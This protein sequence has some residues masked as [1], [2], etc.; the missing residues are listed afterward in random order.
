MKLR[1]TIGIPSAALS[2]VALA[3]L[4]GVFAVG[5]RPAVVTASAFA[6]GQSGQSVPTRAFAW[7]QFNLFLS[8]GNGDNDW[9]PWSTWKT[10]CQ[11]GLVL[12]GP[13]CPPQSSNP[14]PAAPDLGTLVMSG[15]EIPV[16]DKLF[17]QTLKAPFDAGLLAGSV[18]SASC[19]LARPSPCGA[20]L[21]NAKAAG[22][23]Q[24]YGLASL[25]AFIS[26]HPAPS[27][28]P[29]FP[30]G[31]VIVK[32]VWGFLGS[33]TGQLSVWN[34]SD[35][36]FH[37][38]PVDR[39]KSR[40]CTAQAY[41][42]PDGNSN[43]QKI[44][45]DCFKSVLVTASTTPNPGSVGAGIHAVAGDHYV[46]LGIHI[47]RK[48]EAGWVWSTFWWSNDP[49][50]NPEWNGGRTGL[51][52][53]A[54]W[55]HYVANMTTDINGPDGKRINCFNPYIELRQMQNDTVSNCVLCHQFTAYKPVTNGFTLG[56]P[57]LDGATT[58]ADGTFTGKAKVDY[59]WT[60]ADE[61]GNAG[62]PV[63]V[64]PPAPKPK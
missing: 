9:G 25:D 40:H 51:A 48:T 39:D 43:I 13:N 23:I 59:L 28:I 55:S 26:T 50:G 45:L 53:T 31:S 30:A 52:N 18:Q 46:L 15:L 20:I 22:H 42:I 21:Y 38:V 4:L 5:D 1:R 2:L 35:D 36:L 44:P 58:P 7:E 3:L 19:N 41:P 34:Y 56:S 14:P 29:A 47:L 10:K 12:Q 57:A 17:E 62:K 11:L 49:A 61:P 63:P 24:K 54:K 8:A 32:S 64:Q 60:L 6:G 33:T 16:Q 37:M 27:S